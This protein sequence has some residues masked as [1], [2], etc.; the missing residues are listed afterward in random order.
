ML[1]CTLSICV[2]GHTF[3]R[4]TYTFN[5]HPANTQHNKHVIINS[6]RRFDVII[7]CLLRAVFAG[8]K[9]VFPRCWSF[10]CIGFDVNLPYGRNLAICL[11][12]TPG[13]SWPRALHIFRLCQN[14]QNFVD[15]IS[16]GFPCVIVY[17]FKLHCNLFLIHWSQVMNREW[18]CSWSSADRRSEWI[19]M[20]LATMVWL[21]LGVW[22]YFSNLNH[23]K[24][25]HATSFRMIG[26]LCF[27]WLWRGAPA[28]RPL[29]CYKMRRVDNCYLY[30]LLHSNYRWFETNVHQITSLS[31][32]MLIL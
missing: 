23:E 17:W 26:A 32:D 1:P 13:K 15:G 10:H 4:F 19:K 3:A 7:T 14:C 16:N 8:L 12:S 30:T 29:K 11:A 6:K 31:C 27:V 25:W 24:S 20:L 9:V 18:I 5:L 22:R 2:A 21:V 28:D